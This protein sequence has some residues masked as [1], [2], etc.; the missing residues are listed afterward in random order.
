LGKDLRYCSP[1]KKWLI[2]DGCRWNIDE[3]REIYD[4]GKLSIEAMVEKAPDCPSTDDG[5]NLIAHSRRSSTARKVEAM[6][7]TASSDPRIRIALDAL[8]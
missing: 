7:S 3:L 5:L 8:D 4:M 1:W 6:L 2:W